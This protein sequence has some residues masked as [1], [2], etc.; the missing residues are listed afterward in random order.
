MFENHPNLENPTLETI[1]KDATDAKLT[2]LTLNA[3]CRLKFLVVLDNFEDIENPGKSYVEHAQTMTRINQQYINFRS[4]ILKHERNYR[5]KKTE[6]GFIITT[7]GQPDFGMKFRLELLD[8]FENYDLLRAVLLNRVRMGRLN[9]EIIQSLSDIRPEVTDA[10]DSWSETSAETD[11]RTHPLNVIFAGQSINNRHDIVSQI[12]RWNPKNMEG[13]PDEIAKYCTSEMLNTA[14]PEE[15]NLLLEA[16]KNGHNRDFGIQD[17]AVMCDDLDIL[18]SY[19]QINNFVRK[20][21]LDRQWFVAHPTSNTYRWAHNIYLHLRTEYFPDD[22]EG[23]STSWENQ[24]PVVKESSR[25]ELAK[26]VN[27]SSRSPELNRILDEML[28]EKNLDWVKL[29]RPVFA[30]LHYEDFSDVSNFKFGGQ[31]IKNGMR[32]FLQKLS[33]KRTMRNQKGT[34]FSTPS[35]H[36]AIEK[37]TELSPEGEFLQKILPSTVELYKKYDTEA[38]T[39]LQLRRSKSTYD[40]FLLSGVFGPKQH[41]EMLMNL[42]EKTLQLKRGGHYSQETYDY[43]VLCDLLPSFFKVVSFSPSSK[44]LAMN[45][46]L[47]ILHE[48]S[49]WNLYRLYRH[50]MNDTLANEEVKSEVFWLILNLRKAVHSNKLSIPKDIEQFS[51]AIITPHIYSLERF[52]IESWVK[53]TAKDRNAVE[54]LI[55]RE[56]FSGGCFD[57]LMI[58]DFASF[59]NEPQH[60]KIHLLYG[61]LNKSPSMIDSIIVDFE[62]M[63]KIQL[64]ILKQETLY[65]ITRRSGNVM[66]LR[67]LVEEFDDGNGPESKPL[68]QPTLRFFKPHEPAKAE[69]MDDEQRNLILREALLETKKEEMSFA[70]FLRR[71]RKKGV[72]LTKPKRKIERLLSEEM[73]FFLPRNHG[74]RPWIEWPLD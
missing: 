68:V 10:F 40:S 30:F 72:H 38:H 51:D 4:L 22:Q 6:S 49:A 62:G 61:V 19:A 74:H 47:L 63:E 65:R 32:Q 66:Y 26:H 59:V 5:D 31:I 52:G 17:F 13:G 24:I 44:T 15:R 34:E 69:K 12:E 33:L 73:G 14:I 21:S 55:H 42:L 27:L 70:T 71:L 54:R 50:S 58:N 8:R 46:E 48:S 36:D 2:E 25:I 29:A 16:A 39:L 41:F 43:L 64:N 23:S 7:R 28:L 67:P 20:Y 56:L 53:K 35:W 60:V 3:L 57:C 37:T 18:W 1:L 9:H 45:E 11:F